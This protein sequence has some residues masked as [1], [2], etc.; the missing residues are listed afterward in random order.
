[1]VTGIV[2]VGGGMRGIYSAGILDCF[3]KNNINFDICIGVSAGSANLISFLA[4]QKGRNY[5]FYTDYAFR[6]NY[7]S[8]NHFLKTGSYVNLDYIYG[9]LSFTNG[10]NPL[11][12]DAVRENPSEFY[13]VAT[14]AKTGKAKYFNKNDLKENNYKPLMASSCVPGVNKPYYIK[15]FP[16]FDG[17]LSDPV[18]FEKA[19]EL[20]CDRVLLILSKPLEMLRVQGKDVYLSNM[21]KNK[22]PLSAEALFNRAENYNKAVAKA[23]KLQKE[24]KVLILAPDDISGVDTLKREKNALKRL[25]KKGFI[26]GKNAIKNHSSFFEK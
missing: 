10:E 8:V 25:Y 13:I 2:D 14:E 17:A 19:F 4:G 1:M 9:D 7:M 3:M 15:G 5:Q 24:G 26:D 21:I 23:K 12:Y 6:K 22:Y 18:P 20:G 11:D 16:Y